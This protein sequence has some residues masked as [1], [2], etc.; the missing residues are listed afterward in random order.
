MG[1]HLKNTSQLKT[2]AKKKSVKL[3]S[4]D[5]TLDCN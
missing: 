4:D 1:V 3:K 5:E 2:H